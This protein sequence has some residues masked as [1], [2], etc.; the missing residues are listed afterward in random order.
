MQLT[1][2]VLLILMISL[3]TKKSFCPCGGQVKPWL[4]RVTSLVIYTNNG[5]I[6]GKHQEYRCSKCGVGFW[7][8]FSVNKSDGKMKY[9]YEDDCLEAKYLVTSERTAFEMSFLW[10]ICLDLVVHKAAFEAI[11]TKYNYKHTTVHS[12][13][14]GERLDLYPQ[15]CTEAFYLYSLIDQKQRYLIS[16]AVSRGEEIEEALE[17]YHYLIKPKFSQYWSRHRCEKP[18][19]GWCMVFDGG[20]KAN[21]RLCSA[22]LSQVRVFPTSQTVVTTGCTINPGT[23]E[24]YC[25]EHKL[26]GQ[27]CISTKKIPKAEL[28]QIRSSRISDKSANLHEDTVLV[29]EGI[30]GKKE[31]KFCVKWVGYRKVSWLKA[32]LVPLAFRQHYERT[33][34][35]VDQRLKFVKS[36]YG[37]FLEI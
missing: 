34:F 15:R 23:K 36:N 27:P 37:N 18:G 12:S 7:H 19:C 20:M 14:E 3:K 6:D 17:Y 30:T 33:G 4:N 10:D 28:E 13:A 24:R 16:G 8:G 22:L 26:L 32:E 35:R 21:R 5:T 25:K 31:G 2:V 11:C 1:Q 29:L 9:S